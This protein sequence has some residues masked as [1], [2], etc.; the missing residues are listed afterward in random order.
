M[1]TNKNLLLKK[2]VKEFVSITLL[3]KESIILF[4]GSK[5]SLPPQSNSG[6]VPGHNRK[7]R[8]VKY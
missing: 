6:S 2:C 7:K 5:M 3:L 1:R 8:N 4:K